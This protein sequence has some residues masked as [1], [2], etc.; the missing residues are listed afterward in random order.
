MVHFHGMKRLEML[1]EEPCD[2]G[3]GMVGSCRSIAIG[4]A[5]LRETKLDIQS[6]IESKESASMHCARFLEVTPRENL[7]FG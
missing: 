6:Q 4:Q 1:I 5:M 7:R 3:P 2:H